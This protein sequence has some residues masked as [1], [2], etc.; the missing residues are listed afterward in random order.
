MRGSKAELVRGWLEKARRDLVVAEREAGSAA[1]FTD[2]ACFHAQ[3][4]AEKSLKAYLTWR[5]VPFPRTHALEDLVLL[6][7]REDN[8]FA[9]LEEAAVQLTPY[10]VEAR[11]PEFS[12]PAVEDAKEAV[13]LARRIWSFVKQKIPE[14][15][16]G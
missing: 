3:Q 15:A 2:I 11:Y 13:E 9:C 4:S 5:G 14:D 8:S 16:V 7:A 1:P 10:A 12:E 6:A